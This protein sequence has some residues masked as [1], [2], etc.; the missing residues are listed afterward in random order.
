MGSKKPLSKKLNLK[1]RTSPIR[2]KQFTP[3]FLTNRTSLPTSRTHQASVHQK[4]WSTASLTHKH[5]SKSCLKYTSEH[6][7]RTHCSALR[8]FWRNSER[9]RRPQATHS[10]KARQFRNFSFLLKTIAI[11]YFNTS[12][13]N[14][15]RKDSNFNK[16]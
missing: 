15:K 9:R 11:N 2:S 16:L 8:T 4:W 7:W 12:K 1:K 6:R 10:A 13:C 5:A 3:D 14:Q